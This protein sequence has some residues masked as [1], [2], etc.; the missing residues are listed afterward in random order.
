MKYALA[1]ILV[2]GVCTAAVWLAPAECLPREVSE[3]FG[4]SASGQTEAA[5]QT[6]AEPQTSSPAEKPAAAPKPARPKNP[7]AA[8]LRSAVETLQSL[9]AE[10]EK[11]VAL[12]R[13]GAAD[14]DKMN[15]AFFRVGELEKEIPALEKK[16]RVLKSK[17]DAWKAARGRRAK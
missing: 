16:V 13:A 1:L 11:C 10:R 4:T 9:R 15:E 17:Y 5:P 2:A 3:F 14:T 7:H 12:I 8:E 6:A